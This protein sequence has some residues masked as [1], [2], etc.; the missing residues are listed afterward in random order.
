MLQECAYFLYALLPHRFNHYI[1]KS[2]SEIKS[3]DEFISNLDI[4]VNQARKLH[5]S[6]NKVHTKY[7]SFQDNYNRFLVKLMEAQFYLD[8]LNRECH[9]DE[10]SFFLDINSSQ[11]II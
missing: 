4:V 10:R 5:S 3:E 6:I 2:K 7:D 1:M 9:S 11:K 8:E